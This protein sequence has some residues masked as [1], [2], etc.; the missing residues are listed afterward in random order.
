MSAASARSSSRAATAA[1]SSAR[2][3]TTSRRPAPTCP[4]PR[5]ERTHGRVLVRVAPDRPTTPRG[6]LERVFGLVSVSI[7][8]AGP[9][10][11]RVSRPSAPPPS[12]GARRDRP[13]RRPFKI[14]ARRSD[15]RF[16]LDVD[17]DRAARSAPRVI[18]AHRPARRRARARAA[19]RR[20]DR[21]PRRPSS[22]PHRAR[23]RR[24]A[25]RRIGRV[26][27]LLSGGID[28]PVAG[29]LAAKRGWPWTRIYFH[30]LPYTGEKS[31]E[32]VLTLARQL[33]AWQALRSVTV[34][35]FTDVQKKL[36][37]AGP[38][39]AGRRPL[40]PHD[41]AHRRRRRRRRGSAALVTGENLGQVASQ[42]LENMTAI[43]EAARRLVLRPLVTYD[44]VETIALARRIGTYET[45]ILP[46]DDCC[47]LFV[48]AAPGDPRHASR[49]P[50]APRRSWTSRPR[51]P[52]RSPAAKES[53]SREA[54]RAARSP[55]PPR[56]RSPR[57]TSA[58]ARSIAGYGSALV[59]LLGRRRLGAAAARSPHDELGARCRALTAVSI[60]D[61]APRATAARSTSRPGS[62]P[63]STWSSRTSSSAPASP[64]NP[65][66]R[67][68]HCKAELLELARPRAD[69]LGLGRGAARHQPRRPRR[70]PPRPARRQRARRAPPA[71]RRRA[72]QGRRPR[73]CRGALGLPTWD[74]P[75]LAC[76]SSR[77]P[78]GTEITP[79]RLRRVDAFEDGLR[80][81]G[82][83][84][85]RVRYHGDVARLEL[86]RADMPRALE[87]ASATRSSPSAAPHGFTFVALDLGRLRLRLAEP[88]DRD[89]RAGPVGRAR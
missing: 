45:S 86:E 62:A 78:Y 32:K 1:S 13:P 68:Y 12:R 58:C 75:Q 42:T 71:G 73:R 25:R 2:W 48:P 30:S 36:R 54:I 24:P 60:D 67:C 43:E 50:S 28:S 18:D 74:K 7:A 4:A 89:P 11:A 59:C 79:E 20:R 65:T 22:S 83:R 39:R 23:A 27:L 5:V 41:D 6:R 82:F 31:Q 52:P 19:H 81:L 38:G 16:P 33:A 17:G 9:G 3:W 49:T 56:R 47:S 88:A 80:A 34:V 26:A 51:S 64:Q 87:P 46:Y 76:L 55:Q 37:D 72:H 15:K 53:R 10:G 44:K 63:R 77:F 61:G 29:W 21:L 14:E 40:P 84:Q 66:D 35:H 70:P 57:S 8:R 69:A 85:L